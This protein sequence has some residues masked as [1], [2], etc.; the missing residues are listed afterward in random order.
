MIAALLFMYLEQS[1]SL[2][3]INLMFIKVTGEKKAQTACL[4]KTDAFLHCTLSS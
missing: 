4:M 1:F 2:L 3:L